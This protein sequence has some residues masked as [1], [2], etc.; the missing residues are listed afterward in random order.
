MDTLLQDFR[1]SV[2]ML[3][4]SPA[5]T[6]A[7]AAALALGIGANTAMFS[8]VNAVLLKPLPY[9]D[10]TRLVVFLNTSPQGSGPGASPTKFRC[11]S[12][13]RPSDR[14]VEARVS[15]GVC[16]KEGLCAA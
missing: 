13:D 7:V 14:V 16:N 10:P 6:I 3:R 12:R 8:V 11:R 9:L 15:G 1:H 4:R 2:R 5:F